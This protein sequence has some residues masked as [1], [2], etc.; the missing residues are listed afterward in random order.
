[1]TE[2]G[3]AQAARKAAVVAGS[4]LAIDEEAEPIGVRHLSRLG[5]VLQFD[6]GVGHGGKTEGAQAIDC[7]MNEH[8]DISPDQL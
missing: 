8:A 5:I 1:M 2:L 6:E 3:A 7:G 4:D